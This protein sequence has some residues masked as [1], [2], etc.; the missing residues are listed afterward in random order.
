MK[1]IAVIFRGYKIL[2]SLIPG[3]FA[4]TTIRALFSAVL[5]FV[6]II[7]SAI[8]INAIIDRQPLERVLTLTILVAVI[9]LLTQ[10]VLQLLKRI[11]NY[12][13]ANIRWIH[14]K[15]LNEKQ[16]EMDFTQIEDPETR[17]LREKMVVHQTIQGKGIMRLFSLYEGM[18]TNFL[19]VIFSIMVFAPV[20]TSV[21]EVEGF[22][23]FINTPWFAMLL[24]LVILGNA[25]L[26]MVLTTKRI[27]E[28]T[29]VISGLHFP[30]MVG[31][32]YKEKLFNKYQ[33]GKD[34]KVN[35]MRECIVETVYE[36][37]KTVT[38]PAI[39][40]YTV[41][42]IKYRT[43][44]DI[45]SNALSAVV[46]IFVAARTVMGHLNIG[47]VVQYIGAITQFNAGF[48]GLATG[49]AELAVN[50]DALNSYFE[51]L[52]KPST[53]Y[54][55]TLPV[56]KQNDKYEIEFCNVSFRYPRTDTYALK[57]LNLKIHQGQRIAIVGM[58]G[59]GKTT[60]IRFIMS[61]VFRKS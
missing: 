25:I 24:L 49:I 16:Q 35:Q 41:C 39:K 50:I 11:T 57:N 27:N 52:D 51:F 32:Y 22:L 3:Y 43:M 8:I 15:P 53:M 40:K 19:I 4:I 2:H 46:Y 12:L 47:G 20:L 42:E 7:A 48:T 54:H 10:I 17:L 1:N 14:E 58:N 13:S 56:E 38:L 60:M 31:N 37:D 59:S 45:A 23:Q 44:G 34:V 21:G 5:P 9:N 30:T 29:A 36:I 18:V 28:G 61:R 6:N 55:G 26:G 33:A